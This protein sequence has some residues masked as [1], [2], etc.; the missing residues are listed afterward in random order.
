MAKSICFLFISSMASKLPVG[1]KL[2][3]STKVPSKSLAI[4]LID[5]KKPP[6]NKINSIVSYL[7]KNVVE[8]IKKMKYN[9]L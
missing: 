4:S 1:I 6:C 2:L 5:M 8:K 7:V 3:W 9:V